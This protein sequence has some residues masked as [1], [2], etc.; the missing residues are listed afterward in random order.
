MQKKFEY[1]MPTRML[2]GYG[3]LEELSNQPLKF[4][5]ALIVTTSGNSVVKYGYLDKLKLQLDKLKIGYAVYN[6]ISPNPN[7]KEVMEGA[8]LSKKEK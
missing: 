4:R 1:Y 3:A 8:K 7:L 6:N 2:F 5:K